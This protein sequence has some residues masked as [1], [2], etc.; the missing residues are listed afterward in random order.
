MEGSGQLLVGIR[1]LGYD[2]GRDGYTPASRRDRATRTTPFQGSRGIGLG[3][4]K[5]LGMA[6]RNLRM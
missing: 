1:D 6:P 2:R 3:V 5:Y 4:I